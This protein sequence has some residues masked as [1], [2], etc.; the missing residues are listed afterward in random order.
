LANR[1]PGN[2]SRNWAGHAGRTSELYTGHGDVGAAGVGE[3]LAGGHGDQVPLHVRL[4][5]EP[6]RIEEEKMTFQ[7]SNLLWLTM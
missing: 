1:S 4:V 5:L 7:K 6:T 2:L 3:A